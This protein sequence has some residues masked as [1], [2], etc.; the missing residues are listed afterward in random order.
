[1][2]FDT[3]DN[4]F[5]QQ[6]VWRI[7]HVV[8]IHEQ[9]CYIWNTHLHN[10]FQTA[11]ATAAN[12]HSTH[13][14]RIP[15]QT[16]S[17]RLRGS[18]LSARHPYVG[19]V[20]GRRHRINHVNWAHTYQ[21]WLRQQWNSILFSGEWRFTIHRGDGRVRIYPRGNELYASC[22]VLEQDH[23]GGKGYVLVWVG[24][25]HGFHT[26]LIIIKENLNAQCYQDKIIVRHVNPHLK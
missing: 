23:F 22:C 19:C 11:T 17:N 26:N 2:L 5:M 18:R 8:M 4:I 15:A 10:R 14:N 25:S 24:I 6:G 13:N 9:D 21:R 7:D 12:T 1:M 20:L 16:V 3:L